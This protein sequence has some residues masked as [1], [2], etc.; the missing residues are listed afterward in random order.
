MLLLKR[1][2]GILSGWL[3]VFYIFWGMPNGWAQ[4]HLEIEPKEKDLGSLYGGQT[5]KLTFVLKNTGNEM[6]VLEDIQLSC[7]CLSFIGKPQR[8]RP[9][10]TD[11]LRVEFNSEKFNGQIQKQIDI[12]TNEPEMGFHRLVI[13]A[14]IE[15]EWT[16]KG[17]SNRLNYTNL[18]P[19]N[20]FHQ[21]ISLINTSNHPITILDLFS[22]SEDVSFEFQ[23]Q[24]VDPNHFFSFMLE[25][26]PQELGF[27]RKKIYVK[28]SSSFQPRFSINLF[29]TV[30]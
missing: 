25:I 18:K 22:S 19:G 6:L 24:T 28:T 13:N 4:A 20:P 21:K 10:E 16:L 12:F 5:R 23:N 27:Y 9:S 29:Y 17:R 2:F 26:T 15:N 7:N 14:F 8:I 1:C 11:T 3:V 30:K